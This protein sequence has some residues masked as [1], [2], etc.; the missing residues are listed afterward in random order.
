MKNL[1]E[2]TDEQLALSYI[3]GS[4][5]AF[6]LLLSRNQSK[7][8]SYILFVVRDRDA[9][10]DLFQETFVKIITKFNREDTHQQVSS[11]HGL[12]ALLIM[13]LWTGIVRSV[14]IR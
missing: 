5:D 14:Q 6:D 3:E 4:N 8:F 9:A 7:L 10:D 13:L 2:M 11:L 1:N 12:C